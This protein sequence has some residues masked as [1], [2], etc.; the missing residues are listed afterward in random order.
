MTMKQYM[1]LREA[2]TK[3]LFWALDIRFKDEEDENKKMGDKL[4]EEFTKLGIEIK[5]P[6]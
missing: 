5:F 1:L 4:Q 2:Y 3:H 6:E